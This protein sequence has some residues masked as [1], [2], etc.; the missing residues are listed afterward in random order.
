[1]HAILAHWTATEIGIGGALVAVGAL[2]G[3]WVAAR[4]GRT[5]RSR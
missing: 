4:L 3:L 2:A 5:F 1:M